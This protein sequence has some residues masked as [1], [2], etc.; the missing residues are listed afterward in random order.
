MSHSSQKSMMSHLLSGINY[1]QTWEKIEYGLGYDLGD[2]FFEDKETYDR[3]RKTAKLLWAELNGYFDDGGNTP[4]VHIIKEMRKVRKITIA[5]KTPRRGY[6]DS[7]S[8][9]GFNH[10]NVKFEDSQELERV[11]GGDLEVDV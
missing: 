5:S 11:Y 6:V 7:K 9:E 1:N 4:S 8:L 3:V 10:W 2:Y